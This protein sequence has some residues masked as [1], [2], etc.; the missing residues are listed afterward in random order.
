MKKSRISIEHVTKVNQ[1]T[2]AF[3]NANQDIQTRFA[4]GELTQLDAIDKMALNA[5]RYA[6]V[7]REIANE[8]TTSH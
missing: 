3:S 5:S 7:L 8:L 6:L 1:A 2:K 4:L